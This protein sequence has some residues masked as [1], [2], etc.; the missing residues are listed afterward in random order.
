MKFIVWS[1]EIGEPNPDPGKFWVKGAIEVEL[2]EQRGAGLMTVLRKEPVDMELI[3]GD[4]LE[5]S[6]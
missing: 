6:N 1:K 2:D 4:F 3:V 5:L